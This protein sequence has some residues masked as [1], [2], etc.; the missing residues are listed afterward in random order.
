MKGYRER[1]GVRCVAYGKAPKDKQG[2][3][4]FT[5][6]HQKGEEGED[7]NLPPY[8]FCCP[9][10]ALYPGTDTQQDTLSYTGYTLYRA[11]LVHPA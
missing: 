4:S 9:L 7:I 6:A 1:E 3:W 2:I 8:A 5:I 10:Y 11:S